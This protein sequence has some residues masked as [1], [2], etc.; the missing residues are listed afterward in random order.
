MT[1]QIRILTSQFLPKNTYDDTTHILT[2]NAPITTKVVCF[3]RLLIC[4]KSLYGKQCGPRPDC[5]ILN[6]MNNGQPIP[7]MWYIF[8]LLFLRILALDNIAKILTTGPRLREWVNNHACRLS[9]DI[10]IGQGYHI[11]SYRGVI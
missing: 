7:L 11:T 9:H 4:L 6:E 2:L 3:S 1:V 8:I 5:S 10:Q